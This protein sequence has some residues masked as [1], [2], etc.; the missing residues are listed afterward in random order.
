MPKH[1]PIKFET[2]LQ[3]SL[4][5]ELVKIF[6]ENKKAKTALNA[7]LG[8]IAFGG[9]LTLGAIAPNALSIFTNMVASEKRRRYKEY[10][11]LWKNFHNLK[12][13]RALE[14]IKEEDG[15]LIY[16]TT[17]KGHEKI[18]KFIFD[19]INLAKPKKWDG[20][21]RLVIFDIPE[22]KKKARAGLRKKLKE[23]EFYQCQKSAWVH[24]LH[25]VEE[26]EFIKDVLNIKPFVKIFVVEEMDDG[27]VLYH[28]KS[29]VKEMV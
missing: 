13:Q 17:E 3:P 15:Y 6:K 12:K 8:I 21:W 9:I 26:I 24:P 18:K 14:F 11:S 29:L 23:M 16:K 20:K 1:K 22:T 10:Q 4:K 2:T 25:C 27:K 19:E 28:F 7:T 5:R